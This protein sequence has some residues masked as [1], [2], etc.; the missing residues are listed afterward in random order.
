MVTKKKTATSIT[1]VCVNLDTQEFVHIPIIVVGTVK[2]EKKIAKI[3]KKEAELK[4]LEF[5]KATTEMIKVQYSMD[6]ENFYANAVMSIY[7]D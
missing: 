3:C 6:D 4:G 7:N 1:A 2:S 5:V